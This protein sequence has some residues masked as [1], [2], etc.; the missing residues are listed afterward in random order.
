L[1]YFFRLADSSNVP[2][3]EMLKNLQEKLKTDIS[4]IKKELKDTNNVAKKCLEFK[5]P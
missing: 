1:N 5:V 4:D 2:V 3:D